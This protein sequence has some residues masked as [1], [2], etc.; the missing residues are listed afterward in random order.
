M[1]TEIEEIKKTYNLALIIRSM[2]YEAFIKEGTNLELGNVRTFW[3]THIKIAKSKK[4]L[5]EFIRALR[6]GTSVHWH[7]NKKE[8]TIS[9]QYLGVI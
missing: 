4:L 3:Y 1:M 6:K 8:I 9:Q 5:K 2:I 7:E